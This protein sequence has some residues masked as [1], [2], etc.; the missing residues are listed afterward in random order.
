MRG[1]AWN[2]LIS[3]LL[4]SLKMEKNFSRKH[5]AKKQGRNEC[6]EDL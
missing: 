3:N 6:F 4:I 2:S 5:A 1:A